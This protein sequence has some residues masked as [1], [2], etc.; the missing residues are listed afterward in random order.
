M[1]TGFSGIPLRSVW[2]GCFDT[3]A[4]VRRRSVVDA[5]F[6][7]ENLSSMRHLEF[8][9]G[10]RKQLTIEV[11]LVELDWPCKSKKIARVERSTLARHLGC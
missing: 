7:I 1:N 5:V 11:D 9:F 10:N 8:P 4:I 2:F 3:T 6:R